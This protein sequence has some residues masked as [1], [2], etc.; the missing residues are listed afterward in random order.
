MTEL[1]ICRLNQK[2]TDTIPLIAIF[3]EPILFTKN[4]QESIKEGIF[5]EINI[6]FTFFSVNMSA[7]LCSCSVTKE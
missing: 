4:D 2:T 6:L 1:G 3:Q 5:S 7:S